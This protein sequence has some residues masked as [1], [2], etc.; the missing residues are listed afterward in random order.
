MK[1]DFKKD[2]IIQVAV[3]MDSGKM[4][5]GKNGVWYE[6]N[7][8]KRVYNWLKKL[9]IKT[10][11]KNTYDITTSYTT[12]TGTIDDLSWSLEE[13]IGYME[14]AF[15][16]NCIKWPW[17]DIYSDNNSMKKYKDMWE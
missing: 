15:G 8:I 11:F 4:W 13:T 3:D 14:K 10:F 5:Y 7:W 1:T 6:P 16:D 2:G 9:Y 17:K 12:N